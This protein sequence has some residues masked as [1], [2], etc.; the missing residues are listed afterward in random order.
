MSAFVRVTRAD[1]I[2]PEDLVGRCFETGTTALLIEDGA[3]PPAFF[4]LSTGIAGDVVQKVT[5]YQ[6]RL[7]VVVPDLSVHSAHFR[8][9][10]REAGRGARFRFFPTSEEAASWLEGS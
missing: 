10:A 9:F 4:D 7:A 8:D 1:E 2:A 3:L 6:L 5:N